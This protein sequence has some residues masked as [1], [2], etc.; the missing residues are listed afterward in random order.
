MAT[1][2]AAPLRPLAGLEVS[3]VLASIVATYGGAMYAV[4]R[5]ATDGRGDMQSRS[6]YWGTLPSAWDHPE[7][8]YVVSEGIGEFWS[9]LT[10]MPV[11]G[12]MLMYQGLRYKYSGQVLAIYGVTC[13]MYTL[14]FTAHMTLQKVTFAS[15]VISVM[16]NALLTFAEFSWVAHRLLH[17][18][19]LRALIV[20]SAEVVLVGT[21]VT[22]P[23]AIENGGVWTLFI[24]QSPGVFL[25]TA[26]GFALF[27]TARTEEERQTFRLVTISGSLLSTA[28][29]CSFVECNI[30]FQYGFLS[31]FW[32]FPWLHI[33][34][35]VLEQVGIYLFGVGVASL[36]A[37][38]LPPFR[39]EAEVRSVG[40]WP[41]LYC[42]CE[43]SQSF[44]SKCGGVVES[45]FN[46]CAWCGNTR[47]PQDSE[48]EVST[49]ADSDIF[50][51]KGS[52]GTRGRSAAKTFPVL[53][54]RNDSPAPAPGSPTS[55]TSSQS[56]H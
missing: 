30:G 20:G 51:D 53:R 23:Y 5:V 25:A 7:P 21:V 19:L 24:V 43:A 54:K 41:Y 2:K 16:S 29:V 40:G 52:L 1:L 4:H 38:L 3:T 56:R 36:D 18:K 27:S 46:F 39:P 44:C 32:G 17:S 9:V 31:N 22:L 8:N 12:V 11:A 35:H 50:M 33:V 26:I 15:T 55:A 10:T 49:T 48:S 42:P 14:A 6:N 34:I 28:M 37:L 13:A 45:G 47:Q